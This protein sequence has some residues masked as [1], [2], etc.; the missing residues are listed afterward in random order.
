[1]I[2]ISLMYDRSIYRKIAIRGD[3]TLK[4]LP[5]VIERKGESPPQYPDRK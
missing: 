1:M 5:E 2:K 4:D 3:Q